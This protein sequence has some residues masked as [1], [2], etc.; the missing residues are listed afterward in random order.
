MNTSL[1]EAMMTTMIS[2]PKDFMSTRDYFDDWLLPAWGK[3]EE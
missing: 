1:D 2:M 3:W